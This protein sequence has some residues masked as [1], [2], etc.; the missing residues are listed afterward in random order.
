MSTTSPPYDVYDPT[1]PRLHDLQTYSK[2]YAILHQM[3]IG[4][5]ISH[6][7]LNEEQK[8][9]QQLKR[10]V[11]QDIIKILPPNKQLHPGSKS[12]APAVVNSVK[13][14]EWEEIHRKCR[15]EEEL[16]LLFHLK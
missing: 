3:L 5:M 2:P 16:Q 4:L 7:D 10:E 15:N 1:K 8:L 11:L 13:P 9:E 12:K 14:E 6:A